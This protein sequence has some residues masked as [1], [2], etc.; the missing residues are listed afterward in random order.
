MSVSWWEGN[1]PASE[2]RLANAVT[3]T[4]GDLG[5]LGDLDDLAGDLEVWGE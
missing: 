5:D 3:Y 1:S 4:D 2:N